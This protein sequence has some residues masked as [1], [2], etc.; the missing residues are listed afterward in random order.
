[1][2]RKTKDSYSDIH[3]LSK[4]FTLFLCTNMLL[5]WDQETYMP[6]E[7]I[8]L[9]SQQMEQLAG[10]THKQ[11]TSTKFSKALQKLIDLETGK[12]FNHELPKEQ[13]AA[14]REWRRD[15]LRDAKLPISFVKKFAKATSESTHA[16]AEARKKKQFRHFLPHLDKIV[17]LCRKKADLLGYKE[18][19]YD[20]LLD[21]YEPEMTAATLTSLFGRLR[22]SLITILQKAQS[23]P[24]IN[25]QFLSGHF[26]SAKQLELA[27]KILKLMGFKEGFSRLDQTVHPM[28]LGLHPKDI[29]MTTRI[30][31]D[32]VLIN[33]F[34]VL[35]EGG[36][37]LYRLGIPEK[38]FGGPL[39]DPISY[40]IDESQ[41]RLWEN[42]VGRS[43]PF[44]RYFFPILQEAFPEQLGATALNDFYH[45]VNIV[46]P[47]LIRTDSD[48][49]TYNLHILVRF[50]L[51]K[52]LIEGS[53]KPRDIPELWNEKMKTYLGII[54]PDDAQGC[55]QDIHWSLGFFGYFPS[56][57]LGNLYSAQF[58]HA[59][60]TAHPSWKEEMA[61]GNFT[62]LRQWLHQEIHQYGRGYTP[63]EIVRRVA[64]SGLSEKPFVDYLERKYQDIYK[65]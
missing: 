62:P 57:S 18:H 21:L 46:Q 32:N 54:P 40:G 41:S 36:H 27:H 53:V 26:D 51:E 29:R 56:Y 4:E 19:P 10:L 11:K 45:A 39:G 13:Q 55:M 16:W 28:C 52:A 17:T 23:K 30:Y 61:R 6:E 50:E 59:F 1:M 43:L 8:A 65:Y 14:L 24:E 9:R 20:A 2:P 35:H 44:W 25:R 12:I 22:S 64:K 48:E 31:P 38:E 63:D 42:L 47:T 37:G 58:F 33:L 5:E 15:Y 3:K 60:E 7:A 34:S 49:V